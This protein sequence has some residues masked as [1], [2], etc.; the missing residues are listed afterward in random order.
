MDIAAVDGN[1]SAPPAFPTYLSASLLAIVRCRAQVEQSLGDKV[2]RSENDLYQH[3][4]MATVAD[5]VVEGICNEV[6]ARKQK[7]KVRQADRLANELEFLKNTLKKF[8]S[9]DSIALLDST[10]HVVASRA[11]RG[12]DYQGDGPDGLAALEELER[13]G[14]VYVLCLGESQQ[15]L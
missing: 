8:L 6:M 4:S 3:L 10:L 7:L 5:G 14:R 15:V 9:E 12:R 13:L 2:R 1:P 11:G